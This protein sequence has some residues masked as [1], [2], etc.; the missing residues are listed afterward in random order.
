MSYFHDPSANL[1]IYEAPKVGGTTLRLWIAYRLTGILFRSS[2]DS[3]Y[4]GT[5]E[6]TKL[7]VEAGYLH[8]GFASVDCPSRICVKRDP[9][10]RFASCFQ[11]K[12]VKDY[13]LGIS[14]T[15]FLDRFEEIIFEDNV[16]V[17]IYGMPRLAFHFMPQT[18]HFGSDPSYYE[19]VFTLSE[20]SFGVKEYLE[21]KWN[22]KLPDL[23]ARN[24]GRPSENL[25]LTEQEKQRV[26]KIY[27]VDYCHGWC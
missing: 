26:R 15:D 27:E 16:P 12:I 6:M 20:M 19:H 3:Y 14:V 24:A 5:T 4:T 2:L 7:L 13:K 23:H 22:L 21:Q 9:V 17:A 10:E 18:Y 11:D 8:D 1:A 25:A